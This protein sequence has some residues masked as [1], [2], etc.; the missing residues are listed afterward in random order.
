MSAFESFVF[1]TGLLGGLSLVF[2]VLAGIADYL[3]PWL[4][5]RKCRSPRGSQAT[6]RPRSARA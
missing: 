1:V 3:W 2:V 5:R 6:Y 4:E